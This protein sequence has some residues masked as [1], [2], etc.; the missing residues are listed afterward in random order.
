[1]PGDM[2]GLEAKTYLSSCVKEKSADQ[3][4]I[5]EKGKGTFLT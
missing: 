2:A 3:K 4:I 5:S 1:M